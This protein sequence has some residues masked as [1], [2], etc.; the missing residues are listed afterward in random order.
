M[1]D[2]AAESHGRVADSDDAVAEV[3]GHGLGDKT[4]RVGEVDDPGV[5]GEPGD[6]ACDVD[7]DRNGAQ[8]V[9]DAARAHRLLA[10]DVLGQGDPLVGRSA[11]QA[12]DADGGED[13]VRAAQRLVEVGGDGDPR[14]VGH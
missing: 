2:P 9:R 12:A 3:A 4:G 7:G 14:R 1:G 6:P 5:G 8:S 11:L 13:E 10:Q